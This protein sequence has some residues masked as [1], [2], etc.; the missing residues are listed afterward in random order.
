MI[1][2]DP[3]RPFIIRPIRADDAPEVLEIYKPAVL[4]TAFTFE[5]E[6]PS[7][8]DMRSR[9]AKVTETYPW[10]VAEE[11]GRVVGYAYASQ[12]RERIAYRWCVDVS[13][14]IHP[15][16]HR[17]GIGKKL[18]EHLLPI[19]KRQGFYNAYA[20]I[21]IPNDG[22]VLLH[23]RFGFRHLGT[24]RHVGFKLGVWH[25]VG[26]WSLELNPALGSQPTEPTSI[27]QLEIEA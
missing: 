27:R 19:L 2:N 18:Y 16:H 26:W 9:I 3:Q 14:Y 17:K 7:V 1:P 12:H 20:G 8:E 23:E 15:D 25:D 4:S 13:V 5:V 10:I 24:Y 21:T 6:V 22:S 11:G